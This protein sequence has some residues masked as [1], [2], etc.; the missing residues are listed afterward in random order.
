MS[1]QV[2]ITMVYGNQTVYPI[3]DKAKLFAQIAG[4]KTLT[5]RTIQMIKALGYKIEII[6]EEL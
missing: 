4:Q 1:I 6:Q 3:C 5:P 2:R